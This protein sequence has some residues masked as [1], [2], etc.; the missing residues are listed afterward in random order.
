MI[1][2]AEAIRRLKI[3]F[4]NK[5]NMGDPLNWSDNQYKVVSESIAD[6]TN[7]IISISTLKRLFGKVKTAKAYIPHDASLN[8]LSIVIGKD[9]FYDFRKGLNDEL[10]KTAKN[11]PKAVI[12]FLK[13]KSEIVT[14]TLLGLLLIST[15]INF[16]LGFSSPKSKP[17][18]TKAL[19]TPE[20]IMTPRSAYT[21]SCQVRV[22]FDI[23]HDYSYKGMVFMFNDKLFVT[24]KRRNYMTF[25]VKERGIQRARILYRDTIINS[26]I[27]SLND[28]SWFNNRSGETIYF[29]NPFE[30][31]D[32]DSEANSKVFA[33]CNN[34]FLISPDN[35]LM[36]IDYDSLYADYRGGFN[37]KMI[38][39][40][41]FDKNKMQVTLF[42]KDNKSKKPYTEISDGK[43]Y[44]QSTALGK[45][46]VID[47]PG[48]FNF[49][50][51]SDN[52]E[53]QFKFNDK[54]RYSMYLKEEYG[55][56]RNIKIQFSRI[57]KPPL[58]FTLSDL[59]HK[60]HYDL[61]NLSFDK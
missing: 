15:I 41:I 58:K 14:I 25:L 59:Q 50:M 8:A 37:S 52:G 61:M 45:A 24:S 7:I 54:V 46:L 21:D 19:P 27:F 39:Q 38:I 32:F 57:R 34:D 40:L 16:I 28:T 35:F 3:E 30:N 55:Y 1:N 10:R 51:E 11:K 47:K 17:A 43:F 31:I 48:K 5:L 18:K 20:L 23:P 26:A 44:D 13:S 42:G 49:K 60:V 12:K 22:A 4:I 33:S 2:K 56:L 29:N 9:N 6:E 53:L 36:E